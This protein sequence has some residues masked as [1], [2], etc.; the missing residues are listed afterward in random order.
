MKLAAVT[1][2]AMLSHALAGCT[3]SK[4]TCYTDPGQGS[5]RLLGH[6][7]AT[8]I[9]LT[10]EYCAQLCADKKMPLAG[11]E[12]GSQCYC[13][14]KLNVA[15]PKSSTGCTMGCSAKKSEKW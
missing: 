12:D 5:A 14:A 9:G 3:V 6:A 13:G 8:S 4:G 15:K 11:V 1:S 10:V 7:D 2:L